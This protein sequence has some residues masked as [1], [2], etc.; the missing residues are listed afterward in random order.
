MVETFSHVDKNQTIVKNINIINA[1]VALMEM[2]LYNIMFFLINV[3][4]LMPKEN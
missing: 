2:K 3:S 4:I 1:V